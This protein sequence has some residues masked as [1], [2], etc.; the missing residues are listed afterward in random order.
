MSDDYIDYRLIRSQMS[1]EL[2]EII[3]DG[4]LGKQIESVCRAVCVLPYPDIQFPIVTSFI[5]SPVTLMSTAGILFLWGSSGTGKSQIATI[6]AS[7]YRTDTVLAN[8]TFASLRNKIQHER[9]YDPLQCEF[10]KNFILVWEDITP[11]LL[12]ENENMLSLFK[13]LNR[14]NSRI[15]ISSQIPGTNM[16]FDAFAF[17]V[18]NSIHPLWTFWKLNELKIRM[19]PIWFKK[20]DTMTSEEYRGN[21]Y[22]LSDLNDVEDITLDKL[23]S[24]YHLN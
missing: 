11:S 2:D 16:V 21:S 9:F 13:V 1:S 20:R 6:A 12:I 23:S 18:I 3:T 4:N 22:E 8:S 15:T 7:L 24:H 14:K 5:A 19:F 10:E 17:K